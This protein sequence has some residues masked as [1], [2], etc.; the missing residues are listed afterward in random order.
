MTKDQFTTTILRAS[1]QELK[2]DSIDIYWDI[3]SKLPNTAVG[4]PLIGDSYHSASHLYEWNM[5]GKNIIPIWS[6]GSY[7]GNYITW[8]KPINS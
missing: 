4:T 7:K 2:Q 8:R 3:Y 6:N 1:G 5:I